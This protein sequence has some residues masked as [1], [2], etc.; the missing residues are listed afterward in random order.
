LLLC[1]RRFEVISGDFYRKNCDL[2]LKRS[3]VRSQLTAARNRPSRFYIRSNYADEILEELIKCDP[4]AVEGSKFYLHGSDPTL[5]TSMALKIKNL[6]GIINSVNWLGSREI[7]TPIP[8]GIATAERLGNI[9]ASKYASYVKGLENHQSASHPDRDIRLYASF[10][11]TTNLPFRK[12]AIR[13]A[14]LVSNSEVI[15]SRLTIFENLQKL[16]RSKFVLSPPGVGPDCFRTWESIYAGAVPIVLRSHWPFNHLNLPVMV[17]EC[18]ENLDAQILEF[19]R[20][21]P[22]SIYDWESN[23]ISF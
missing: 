7:V 17:I 15:D 13:Q 1:G 14:K 5:S 6:R 22:K 23:F 9:S 19:E 20:K 10:E 3:I 11:L 18:F 21:A 16:R 12:E 4:T 2:E 8:I